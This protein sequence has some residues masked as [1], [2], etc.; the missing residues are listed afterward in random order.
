MLT[1]GA[2]FGTATVVCPQFEMAEGSLHSDANEMA[3]PLWICIAARTNLAKNCWI[4]QGMLTVDRPHRD[5]RSRLA[6]RLPRIESFRHDFP[7]LGMPVGCEAGLPLCVVACEHSFRE[8]PIA[9]SRHFVQ[10][11][12]T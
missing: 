11:L 10:V 12:R 7:I 9:N 8:L 1:R 3:E 6:R 5:L 4:R 2:G